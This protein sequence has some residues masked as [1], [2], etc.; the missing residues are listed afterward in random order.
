VHWEKS[1]PRR[2]VRIWTVD[3]EVMATWR[4]HYKAGAP[5][6]QQA[7]LWK[8]INDNVDFRVRSSGIL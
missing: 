8:W 7:E 2:R 1:V 3:D 6:E 4:Q 5:P